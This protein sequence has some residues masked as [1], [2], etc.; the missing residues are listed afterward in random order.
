MA[1]K[2]KLFKNAL[3]VF[4]RILIKIPLDSLSETANSI[5]QIIGLLVDNT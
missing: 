4:L 1:D 2:N 5:W 3:N